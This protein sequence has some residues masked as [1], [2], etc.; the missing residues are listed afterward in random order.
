MASRFSRSAW[1]S[2]SSRLAVVEVELKAF[3]PRRE[4]HVTHTT[5]NIPA[6]LVPRFTA[7]AHLANHVW[8]SIIPHG[9]QYIWHNGSSVN[10]TVPSSR[11]Q[12][13]HPVQSVAPIR[14]P[15]NTTNG[16]DIPQAVS[17]ST[18]YT[19]NT[20]PA[21]PSSITANY[22]SYKHPR[23]LYS[24]SQI[25]GNLALH[26]SNDISTPPSILVSSP[27]TFNDTSVIDCPIPPTMSLKD[28]FPYGIPYSV[29]LLFNIQPLNNYPCLYAENNSWPRN[30]K[31]PKKILD[32][33]GPFNEIHLSPDKH[34][35]PSQPTSRIFPQTCVFNIQC[36]TVNLWM[37]SVDHGK[38]AAGLDVSSPTTND[39]RAEYPSNNSTT[40]PIVIQQFASLR[41]FLHTDST[42]CLTTSRRWTYTNAPTPTPTWGDGIGCPRDGWMVLI[43]AHG[44]SLDYCGKYSSFKTRS[45]HFLYILENHF[46]RC[47]TRKFHLR[48]KEASLFVPVWTRQY[49]GPDAS[50]LR[51]SPSTRTPIR[52]RYGYFIMPKRSNPSTSIPEAHGPKVNAS[53][54]GAAPPKKWKM[55]SKKNHAVSENFNHAPEPDT[56]PPSGSPPAKKRKVKGP[57]GQVQP[58]PEPIRA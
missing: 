17:R 46:S 31:C 3:E 39:P 7:P 2:S 38:L 20:S 37:L 42:R 47:N 22:G 50:C 53:A 15:H 32:I 28:I 49:T 33:V 55:K 29:I 11:D 27:S 44:S 10:A 18:C 4:C 56:G 12:V 24:V 45:F 43:T 35:L 13:T 57:S 21:V 5:T 54:A 14:Q 26:H 19:S 9:D 1:A 58:V 30:I 8:C 51:R 48:M 25:G 16:A 23:A 52:Y 34:S 36:L 41:H 40:P 6:D